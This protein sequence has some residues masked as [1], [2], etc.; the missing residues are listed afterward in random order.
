MSCW[1]KGFFFLIL[2]LF[3]VPFPAY[4]IYTFSK[5]VHLDF[6]P[7]L[8]YASNYT[9]WGAPNF[10]IKLTGSLV[11]YATI[12]DPDPGGGKRTIE[13]TLKLPE[14]LSPPGKWDLNV[15]AVETGG[16]Q[17][18]VGAVAG[19]FEPVYIHV[20]Y[21]GYYLEAGI[22]IA[23]IEQNETARAEIVM[24]NYGKNDIT[25]LKMDFN[26]LNDIN[27]TVF[28]TKR[29]LASLAV[30][31]TRSEFVEFDT[32]SIPPGDHKAIVNLFYHGSTA[33]SE[34]NFKIGNV[35]VR[36]LSYPK[37]LFIEQVSKF[38]VEVEVNW[39]ASRPL[40][41][42]VFIDGKLVGT[43]PSLTSGGFGKFKLDFFVD[44]TGFQAGEHD[45]RLN[46]DYGD[47]SKDFIKRIKLIAS[48]NA[49][50]EEKPSNMST[51]TIL[52]IISVTVSLLAVFALI[53]VLVL[54][55]PKL[56]K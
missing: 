20:P 40:F 52:L 50:I 23:N 21:P 4:S 53:V 24:V 30:G 46:I 55:L 42:K 27:E 54:V 48:P 2:L 26:V 6:E 17:G 13:V 41:A 33:S 35:D 49:P 22:N 12:I 29:T 5:I 44:T 3:F 16:S 7:N 1:Q 51:V 34:R 15:G 28:S 11:K 9:F 10:D 18:G 19:I 25:D 8:I 14:Q 37:E 56:K 45:L 43:S 38:P 36:L 39:R 47:G 31:A 32:R